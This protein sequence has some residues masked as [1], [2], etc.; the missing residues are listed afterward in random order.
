MK[1]FFRLGVVLAICVASYGQTTV[2][3]ET[4][5]APATDVHPSVEAA[6]VQ[7]TFE[8]SNLD[9]TYFELTID[10]RGQAS[11]RS[12]R[13]EEAP[14]DSEDASTFQVSPYTRDRIFALAKALDYFN[15][16]FEFR[17]RRIA[18]SGTRTFTYLRDGT[19]HSTRFNWSQNQ[20]MLE[21][22]GIFEG[23][24]ATLE[25][26]MKLNYLRRH[27]K[28]GLNAQLARME[29][30]AKSGTLKELRLLSQVLNEVANDSTVMHIAR[31]R[32]EK[33]ERLASAEGSAK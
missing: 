21:L 31:Q 26:E 8:N 25:S 19:R 4:V 33:L 28:L 12:R 32:A 30:Q 10:D 11:Y 1:R 20:Q 15:G 5:A 29:E 27:D 3:R 7:F 9:P 22:V 23:I 16:D 17:K 24:G 18:F 14:M 13:R 2:P 6:Q